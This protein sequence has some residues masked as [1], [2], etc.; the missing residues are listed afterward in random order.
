M[1]SARPF[2]CPSI[3]LHPR[4]EGPF[5]HIVLNAGVDALAAL[6]MDGLVLAG[7]Q[8]LQV[9]LASTPEEWPEKVLAD[10]RKALEQTR[11]EMAR[12]VPVAELATLNVNLA[13]GG[14]GWDGRGRR[15]RRW[16]I[17]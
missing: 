13:E 9:R 5:L 2:S 10:V 12:R 14:F 3:A 1:N 7:G 4:F 17:F 6:S 8:Q 16:V 11:Q 15:G